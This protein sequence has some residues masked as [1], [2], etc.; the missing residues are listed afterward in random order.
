MKKRIKISLRTKIYI[1]LVALLALTGI[2][3]AANPV[4]F[5]TFQSLTGVAVSKTEMFVTGYAPPN[6]DIYTLNCAGISTLYQASAPSEKYIAIAPAQ[7]VNAGFTPRDVFITYGP[8]IYSATPPGSF[9][10][11]AQTAC[12]GSD[13]TSITFD[14]VGHFQNDMIVSCSEGKVYKI[15]NLGPG[16]PHVIQLTDQAGVDTEGLAVTPDGFGL[17]GTILIGDE[18]AQR[19]NAV[20]NTGPP[21][22]VMYNI[23]N[24]PSGFQP[25]PESLIFVPPAPRCTFCGFTMFLASQQSPVGFPSMFAYPDSD[26]TGLDGQLIIS[27]EQDQ[28]VALVQFLAGNYVTS[29]FDNPPGFNILEN[30]RFVDCDI[31]TPTPTATATFTPTPTPTAT[32]TFTPTP[33]ATF[34]PTPTSTSTP[35]PPPPTPTGTPSRVS[36]ITPTGTTC[37]EFKNG[38]A[39]TLANLNY[40]VSGGNIGQNVTPGVFFYWVSVTVPAGN[41]VVTVTQTITTGNFTGLFSIASAQ[42]VFNSNCNSVPS[43]IAQNPTTGTVTISFNAPVAG[44]YIISIK[45]NSKSI[46]GLPA[47]SP[48]TTVHYDFA[49]TGVPGSTSGLDLIK[50]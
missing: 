20:D 22:G 13:H 5:S 32:A 40:S 38:T 46:A 29:V 9:N 21:A 48:G 19:V 28:R 17:N 35:V 36:K 26:F 2:I 1:T 8:F 42:N 6:V 34:T 27:M 16:A 3:Y 10:L 47:P 11:F 50:N 18:G 30:V 41:N 45:Y 7:S 39:E 4:T 14:K 25:T 37:N 43:T 24:W 44:T 49:T 33:T 23:F 15:D 12:S 31:P